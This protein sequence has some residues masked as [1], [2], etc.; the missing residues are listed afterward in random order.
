MIIKVVNADNYH[1]EY[2]SIAIE[3]TESIIETL[4]SKI[5]IPGLPASLSIEETFANDIASELSKTLELSTRLT[6][7]DLSELEQLILFSNNIQF[8]DSLT[9][10]IDG[11]IIKILNT[12]L[13]T[14]FNYR[15]LFDE[16]LDLSKNFIST[17]V[18]ETIQKIFSFSDS[19]EYKL[20]TLIS[21]IL[22][23]KIKSISDYNLLN[24][25]ILGLEY[26]QFIPLSSFIL[27][28]V[29]QTAFSIDN[30]LNIPKIID[31][32]D[33]ETSEIKYLNSNDLILD[34]NFLHTFNLQTIEKSFSF[35]DSSKYDISTLLSKILTN[36]INAISDY[37]IINT[38]NIIFEYSQSLPITS[39]V[40]NQ[41]GRLA[42]NID[43]Y[44]YMPETINLLD[45]E[46]FKSDYLNS[47]ILTLEKDF[48]STF[49]LQTIEKI[50]SFSDSEIID[51]YLSL[52]ESNFRI[53]SS[54]LIE[55]RAIVLGLALSSNFQMDDYFDFEKLMLISQSETLNNYI[56]LEELILQTE[57]NTY[58]TSNILAF[59]LALSSNF[60]LDNYIDF[61]R[62][63]LIPPSIRLGGI[64]YLSFDKSMSIENISS[65]QFSSLISS[66]LNLSDSYAS[67]ISYPISK[68]LIHSKSFI[69]EFDLIHDKILTNSLTYN[70]D[71]YLDLYESALGIDAYIYIEER[72]LAL[73]LA[74]SSNFQLD[75]LIS[76][77]KN[78]KSV[79]DFIFNYEIPFFKNSTLSEIIN[80]NH[81]FST[82]LDI[83]MKDTAN[84]LLDILIPLYLNS[85]ISLDLFYYSIPKTFTGLLKSIT[86]DNKIISIAYEDLLKSIAFDNDIENN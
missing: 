85:K 22:T 37:N 7:E 80:L 83:N 21:K 42:F 62:L 43:N 52:I 60:L 66:L 1:V 20:S 6:L 30:Y 47:N 78:I 33:S 74:L 79:L 53:D 38:D 70:L 44:L 31:L 50:F 71:N 16:T 41:I 25:D 19:S 73:A 59:N 75:N 10:L 51:N 35:S 55:A 36:K 46:T 57:T 26:S 27:T 14:S 23:N 5:N 77:D 34:K 69:S 18:L 17:F 76:C 29:G 58:L 40:L 15:Y 4:A 72:V 39:F 86:F 54:I 64:V 65:I 11:Y 84:F 48:I 56:S 67:D 28:S 3:H 12:E 81:I 24:S 82:S 49:N 45:S 8:D 13:A 32:L 68:N 61:N 2:L 63:L 9:S